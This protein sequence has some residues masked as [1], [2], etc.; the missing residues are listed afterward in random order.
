M[1]A[2]Q[3]FIVLFLIGFAVS[4]STAFDEKYSYDPQADFSDLKTFD[5]MPPANT[6]RGGPTYRSRCRNPTVRSAPMI[7]RMI[8]KGLAAAFF[9]THTQS[10]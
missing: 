3:I 7:E 8:D 9:R 1:K 10:G 5:W 2:K 4:C 6:D